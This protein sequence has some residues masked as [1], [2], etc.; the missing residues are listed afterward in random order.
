M[1]TDLPQIY[2]YIVSSVPTMYTDLTQIYNYIAQFLD[3]GM[4]PLFHIVY[5]HR[6]FVGRDYKAWAQQS[7][8]INWNL[9]VGCS[10]ASVRM[11]YNVA[12]GVD[13]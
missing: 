10:E 13:L 9:P 11:V 12:T 6:S 3:V 1:Y 7:L 5:H 2:N 8:F 4:C